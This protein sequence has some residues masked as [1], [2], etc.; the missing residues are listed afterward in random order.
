MLIADDGLFP[1]PASVLYGSM[2]P[3]LAADQA[4]AAIIAMCHDRGN[5]DDN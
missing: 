5:A 3:E 4:A 1:F 2:T